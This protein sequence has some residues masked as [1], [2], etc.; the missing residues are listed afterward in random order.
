LLR[1]N[2]YAA[3]LDLFRA[4]LGFAR[5]DARVV[6]LRAG[7]PKTSEGMSQRG[8]ET[9]R[10]LGLI[11]QGDPA[12]PNLIDGAVL[13]ASIGGLPAYFEAEQRLTVALDVP[14]PTAGLRSPAPGN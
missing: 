5:S 1:A 12:A 10:L 7:Y 2:G 11:I 8:E 3:T 9:R 6:N 14:A 4:E 13:Q